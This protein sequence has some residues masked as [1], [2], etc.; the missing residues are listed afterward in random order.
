MRVPKITG[1]EQEYGILEPADKDANP[2]TN[3]FL[4]VN[5]YGEKRT[6][7]WDYNAESPLADARGF[8]RNGNDIDIND[9]DN[10]KCGKP[11]W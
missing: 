1:I 7:I 3:S 5:S 11:T 10:F 4:V 9:A 8:T 6:M 2:V